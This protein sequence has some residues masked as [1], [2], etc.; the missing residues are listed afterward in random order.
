[1][2][3]RD[4]RNFQ[5]I[6]TE[7]E[8][9]NYGVIV[10]RAKQRNHFAS[11]ADINRR[12]IGLLPPDELITQEDIDF[13]VGKKSAGITKKV[14]ARRVGTAPRPASRKGKRR[15]NGSGE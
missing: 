11:N 8:W 13:F 10:G 14:P 2:A 4:N 15:I 12:L 9:E 1:M 3:T 7:E 6:L 5:L